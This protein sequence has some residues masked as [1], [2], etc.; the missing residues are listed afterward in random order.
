MDWSSLG[1]RKAATE[2]V[3]PFLFPVK[4]T[5][6]DSPKI[7]NFAFNSFASHQVPLPDAKTDEGALGY[8]ERWLKSYEAEQYF[9]FSEENIKKGTIF[10]ADLYD[11]IPKD[12]ERR[13]GNLKETYN[14]YEP[15]ELG[16]WQ[17]FGYEKG[18]EDVS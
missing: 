1:T 3:R 17:D 10:K 4:S 18:G 5:H 7:V 15:L 2:L 6:R 16:E 9:D 8:L 12:V 13:M 11:A 14:A